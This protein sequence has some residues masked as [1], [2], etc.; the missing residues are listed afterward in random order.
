MGRMMIPFFL[1]RCVNHRRIVDDVHISSF[2]VCDCP[3]RKNAKKN[4]EVD[5][6]TSLLCLVLFF[7]TKILLLRVLTVNS[8][9]KKR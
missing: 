7:F 6:K 9:V 5:E 3:Q 1:L 4:E 8:F 2:L